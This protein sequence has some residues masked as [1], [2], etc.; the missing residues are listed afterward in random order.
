MIDYIVWLCQGNAEATAVD[1][2]RDFFSLPTTP[3]LV[4]VGWMPQTFRLEP[5]QHLLPE[6]GK[7]LGIVHE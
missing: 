6:V 7:F 5:W 3:R 4:S 2:L 1:V